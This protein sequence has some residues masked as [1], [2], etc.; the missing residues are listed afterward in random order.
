MRRHLYFGMVAFVIS[1]VLKAQDLPILP[2]ASVL[3]IKDPGMNQSAA[4]K[5]L[6]L[7]A[8]KAR[9]ILSGE[10]HYYSNFNSLGEYK[11]LR[12][13]HET[14][15][16]RNFLI[17]LSPT[18]AMYM[19]RY[20]NGG[21]ST[22]K[23]FLM[24]TSSK[25]Y[26]NLFDSIAAWNQSL[27]DTE[28][29]KV[30]GLDVERFYDMTT[31]R[32]GDVFEKHGLPPVALRP[33]VFL[34]KNL[35]HRIV[36]DGEH[37]REEDQIVNDTVLAIISTPEIT[38]RARDSLAVGSLVLN[39]SAKIEVGLSSLDP[40]FSEDFNDFFDNDGI[41]SGCK[42]LY[43]WL[44][45][46]ANVA[47]EKGETSRLM[48]IWLGQD[49]FEFAFAFQQL[50]EWYRWEALD[51]TAQQYT[52][53]EEHMY[54]NLVRLLNADPKAKFFGQFGRCHTSLV[55]QQQDCGWFE[56]NSILTRLRTR[57]F[58]DDTSVMSIGIFYY[59]KSDDKDNICAENLSNNS[60]INREV[61]ALF[62]T[63]D[64]N[65]LVYDLHNGDGQLI[66]L[67]K[68][69]SFV[70]V[71]EFTQQDEDA[72]LDGSRVSNYR[73]GDFDPLVVSL[74]TSLVGL[75]SFITNGMVDHFASNDYNIHQPQVA[76]FETFGFRMTRIHS[77]I[78][79]AWGQ[80]Q[81]NIFKASN[82]EQINYRNNNFLI[83]VLL[84]S[85]QNNRWVFGVG[86]RAWRNRQL[87][88]YIPPSLNF[89]NP[90]ADGSK[91]IM[92]NEWIPATYVYVERRLNEAVSLSFVA[93]Y[94][95]DISQGLWYYKNSHLPYYNGK[96]VGGNMSSSFAEMSLIINI[97]ND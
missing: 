58:H 90:Q 75:N 42:T 94:R 46:Y 29:I 8:Q 89:A 61:E 44:E 53:R 48:R 19:E 76:L 59:D 62:A 93:G 63:I 14:A 31:L 56:Y 79:F 38:D 83:D 10:N 50:K 15:G 18:R 70:L 17:E 51:N 65:I 24:A 9:V 67:S 33:V 91:T 57:Y 71:H 35:A 74:A 66:E 4:V 97:P 73:K 21:D 5:Q 6:S 43:R 39:K 85:G 7:R 11:F 32:L 47:D 49:Y 87:I 13:L 82:G 95:K 1:G 54:L 22:A 64:K 37:N 96:K 3:N 80:R 78:Q 27:A 30:H 60:A 20:F 28:K 2:A 45:K 86:A 34:A 23:K 88:T 55:K 40:L 92:S 72:D 52:W 36:L 68:K 16:V 84:H 41:E 25:Q 12:M 81:T 69:F 77:T 26:M